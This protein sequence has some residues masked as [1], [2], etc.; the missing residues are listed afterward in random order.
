MRVDVVA[1]ARAQ[2]FEHGDVVVRGA[3]DLD[4]G[5]PIRN[6]AALSN[7]D[8]SMR[9]LAPWRGF[10]SRATSS[11]MYCSLPGCACELARWC[12]RS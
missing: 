12:G 4:H 7:S 6:R 5:M 3:H 9:S 8:F 1:A 2:V 10:V 11:R